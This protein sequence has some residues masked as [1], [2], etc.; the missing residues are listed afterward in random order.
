MADHPGDADADPLGS[1]LAFF[2]FR[3]AE[4]ALVARRDRG[5]KKSVCIV[6]AGIAGLVAGYEL[7]RA[8][9][10]VVVVEADDRPG[11]RIRT[12]HIGGLSGEFG[13][14]RIPP[15]HEGTMHYVDELG[16]NKGN[17]VQ[18]NADGWL[19][20]RNQKERIADWVNLIPYYG[21]SPKYL[22]PGVP[23]NKLD[24]D[25]ERMLQQALQLAIQRLPIG[26]LWSVFNGSLG[27]AARALGG[28][29]L[30]QLVQGMLEDL[31]GWA[32]PWAGTMPGSPRPSSVPPLRMFSDAG[33]EF[34]GRACGALWEERVGALEACIEDLWVRGAPRIRLTDGMDSLPNKLMARIESLGGQVRLGV[35]V[36]RLDVE[37]GN[38]RVRV[39]SADGEIFAEDG[40]P[41]EYV[42]CAVP[43]S[44]TARIEF[45][46]RLAPHKYEALTN[47]TY[48][49]AAKTLVKVR[50]RRWEISDHIYGGAS[51]TDLPLQQC[52]YP[53]DNAEPDPEELRV[54]QGHGEYY[55]RFVAKSEDCSREPAVFTAAYMTG[56]NA[57][58]FTSLSD[59]E[60]T[61]ETVRYLEVLHPG[62]SA[63]ILD[64]C[65]FDWIEGR[66][67]GGG[68]WTYFGAGAH[69]RYQEA[70]CEPHPASAPRVFF[71]GEHL[72]VLHGWM[73]SAIQSSLEATMAV[74]DAP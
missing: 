12:W 57:E 18:H 59:A 68:A 2:R 73:Q 4:D 11:G 52:W 8:G 39:S 10:S 45:G 31:A 7:R 58:R 21:G 13:P 29:T 63:D 46:P 74:M 61:D 26:E 56:V 48:L 71:A 33:W 69:E 28:L 72:C 22:F 42:V 5:A 50:Q 6:G 37:A 44:A 54:T 17:F 40:R 3:D 27:P 70:L 15:R 65:H 64:V 60:R 32:G 41:F 16:L 43:A 47:L 9:H 67:P 38:D 14:M 35:R 55:K 30:W 20:L 1:Q 53:A 49:S 25:P 23:F 66:T 24:T 19:L 34:I 51:Y 62:I 36:T